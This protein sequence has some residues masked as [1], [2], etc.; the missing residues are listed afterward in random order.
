MK[1]TTIRLEA[2]K[3]GEDKVKLAKRQYRGQ[4]RYID[5]ILEQRGD[6][7]MKKI[8]KDGL[9]LCKLQVEVFEN[10]IDKMDPS[11]AIE[12]ILEAKGMLMEEKEG[13]ERQYE[14][15]KRI[16]NGQ[17]STRVFE[18]VL[19]GQL[20]AI[21]VRNS[22]AKETAHRKSGSCCLFVIYS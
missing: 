21:H 12:R 5:E 18:F 3:L 11:Q 14:I 17:Q 6:R 9:L 13:L 16:R 2:T 15:F 22:C 7:C 4:G 1:D 8:S 20:R 10:S 19:K